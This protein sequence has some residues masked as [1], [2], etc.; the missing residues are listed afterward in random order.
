MRVGLAAI[1]ISTAAHR[2]TNGAGSATQRQ[3]RTR[4]TQ[5]FSM[6]NLDGRPPM[7]EQDPTRLLLGITLVSRW[8]AG[9]SRKETLVRSPDQ[10][11]GRRFASIQTGALARA[12]CVRA[13]IDAAA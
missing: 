8:D 9:F 2:V 3:L 1:H 6:N 4:V 7:T 5:Y 11:R 13:K 10:S 12:R